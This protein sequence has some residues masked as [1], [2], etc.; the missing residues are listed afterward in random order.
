MLK[1]DE[2]TNS[3]KKYDFGPITGVPCSLFKDFLNY[4]I[5][6]RLL[7]HYTCSSEG[8][9]MGIAAGFSLAGKYPIVYMQ[10]DGYGNAINP[11]SSL[12]LMYNLPVLLIISWRGEP[13]KKDAPQHEIMGKTILDLLDVFK[14]P[15]SFLNES[16]FDKK[17]FTA[18]KYMNTYQKPYAL[19][20]KKGILE[21]L[22]KKSNDQS[23]VNLRYEYIKILKKHVKKDDILLGT[24]GYTGRELYQI[25]EHKSKF[26]MMGSMGCLASIGLALAKSYT[27]KNVYILDGDGAIIM[28]MGTL[29]TIGYYQPKNL[30]HICFN[31]EEYEST[32]GQPTTSAK[33]DLTKIAQACNYK[34]SYTISKP[35]DFNRIM[36]ES[37]K[38]TKPLFFE[39]K[40]KTGSI[41]NL[42][43][44]ELLPVI[45][46]Q[47]F[48]DS[49]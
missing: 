16:D 12:Q 22:E 4:I 19:I 44:P 28:K 3:L 8:E 24:T 11:L 10:N 21:K 27:N 18:K 40:I 6:N 42:K 25:M 46:K 37:N 38:L 20:L 36:S 45:I 30:I 31:N 15:H 41:E 32:G 48:M 2:F 29:S 39:I 17:L 33:T 43:R 26:Y 5:G 13:G 49:L 9:A 35:N 47:D 7:E 1:L 34:S 14:I 23:N